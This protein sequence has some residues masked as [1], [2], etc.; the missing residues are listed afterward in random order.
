MSKFESNEQDPKWKRFEKLTAKIQ[1]DLSPDATVKHNDKILG[2]NTNIHRQIDVSVRKSIGQY[3]ILI[4]IS[5][6]DLAEPVDL[7]HVEEWIGLADDVQANK[8]A[9]VSSKGFSRTAK[10]LAKNKGIDLYTLVDAESEDWN[11]YASVPIIVSI[12][13]VESAELTIKPFFKPTCPL[14]DIQMYDENSNELGTINEL[15]LRKWNDQSSLQK[16]GEHREVKLSNHPLFLRIND[17]LEP[18]EVSAKILGVEKKY[19][20]YVPAKKL[21]ALWDVKRGGFLT[22]HLK[23]DAINPVEVERTWK[24]IDNDNQL[25]VTPSIRTA[26]NRYLTLTLGFPKTYKIK[27]VLPP[28]AFETISLEIKC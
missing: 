27:G 21:Q 14:R 23:T 5:C 3:E 26:S 17:R 22:N 6:K 2:K 24:R 12:V 15:I 13:G 9:I 1:K 28:N 20:G 16:P 7:T 25:A 19:F 8:A 18:V 4:I 11:T 10:T